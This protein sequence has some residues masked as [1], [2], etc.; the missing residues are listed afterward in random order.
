MITVLFSNV[1]VFGFNFWF[2]VV[3]ATSFNAVIIGYMASYTE[4]LS[5]KSQE[6]NSK[7]N[8]TNTAMLNLN[9]SPRLKT[10]IL[11]YIYQT[12]TTKQLQSELT[13]FMT[14]ISPIYKRKV[15]KESFK[16][17]ADTN[18]VLKTIKDTHLELKRKSFPRN[19]TV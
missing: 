6:L 1:F 14:Q 5:K 8:Q 11:Q 13:K 3:T 12:H 17:L 19:F 2:F 9:L 16:A 18:I 10:E 7:L 15:T 4:E